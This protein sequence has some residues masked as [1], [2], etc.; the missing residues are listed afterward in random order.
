MQYLLWLMHL[1]T[2][3][4]ASLVCIFFKSKSHISTSPGGWHRNISVYIF[5]INKLICKCRGARVFA[6]LL[7]PQYPV[8][9]GLLDQMSSELPSH[10][11]TSGY[12]HPQS[13]VL[14]TH[15]EILLLPV[16]FQKQNPVRYSRKI[17][18]KKSLFSKWRGNMS[19]SLSPKCHWSSPVIIASLAHTW[20]TC[21]MQVVNDLIILF[22]Q[23]LQPY[24]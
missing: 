4:S 7:H 8:F 20:P 9:L 24:S 10:N 19:C 1:I 6:Y 16:L 14:P 23:K 3:F 5:L 2:C 17:F 18:L 12:Y 15:W 21:Y 22:S 11:R 13:S